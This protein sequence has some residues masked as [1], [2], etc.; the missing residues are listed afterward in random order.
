LNTTAHPNSNADWHI[1]AHL[2]LPVCVSIDSTLNQWLQ[3]TL[4]SLN[5]QTDILGKICQSTLAAALRAMPAETDTTERPLHLVVLLPTN[6]SKQGQNWGYYLV[7]KL[8]A[9]G[10]DPNQFFLEIELYLYREG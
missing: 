5:L 1:L 3:Q 2:H 10:E 8:E 6:P 9:D 7:E 4:G